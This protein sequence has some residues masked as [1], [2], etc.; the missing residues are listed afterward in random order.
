MI[1]NFLKTAFRCLLKNK[2]FTFINILGLAL[3]LATCLLIVFYVF[4]ELSYDKYNTKCKR[5]YRVNTDLKYNGILTAFGTTSKPVATALVSE[6]PE[7][8]RSARI[9]RALNI[10]FKKGNEIIR[11]DENGTTF[12]CDPGIFEIFT[13]P[14]LYGNPKTALTEPN[15]IVITESI[16]KKYFNR[17][18]VVGQMLFL[19]TDSTTYKIEGVMRDM[20]SQSHFR[21]NFL[22]S[23]SQKPDNN[24]NGIGGFCT[25][26]LLKPGADPKRLE[27]KFIGLMRKHLSTVAGFNY[28]KFEKH[29]NYLRL[30]LTPLK[31]IHLHSNLQWE[32]GA[33]GN[34]QYIYIFSAVALFILLLACI[35]FMNLSTARSANRAREVGVRKVLGSSRKYLIAQFLSESII[36]TL[37]AAIIAVLAAW[38]LLP[39][40]NQ[41]S[42]KHLAITVQIFIW[43]LPSLLSIIIVVGV[44]AGSYPALFLSAF[45]PIDVLKGNLS[46]GFKGGSLRS[47]LIVFQFSISI[48]LVIGTLVVYNQLNYIQN[49]DL[50]FNRDQVLIIKNV[51]AINSP[52]I[53]KREI[54]QLPGVEDAT[55]TSFL[56]TSSSR[57]SNIIDPGTK[58]GPFMQFWSVDEDY[59]NT[60][61]M[62]LK[63]GRN[64]S[65]QFLTD[66]SAM[67]INETAAKMFFNVNEPLNKTLYKYNGPGNEE[68]KYHVIGVVKDFNFSS[69]RDNVTPLVL[70]MAQDGNASLSV[71]VNT[72]NLPFLMKRIESTWKTLAPNLHLEYSFMDDDF[73]AMYSNEQRMVKLFVIFTTL[74]VIIACLGL[75]G[76]AAYAAEQRNREISIRKVLG[77]NVSG[78]VAL[79]S[80]DFIKLV[81]IAIVIATPLAW[82][83]MQKWLQGFAYR[84]HIHWWFFAVTALGAIV[85]A[86]V[87]ISFQSI[88]AAMANPVDSLRSE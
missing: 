2:G 61:G 19:V 63:K 12:Y 70:I 48:F 36:V 77:A 40:F 46:T 41:I 87:T 39:L 80:K 22:M 30:N 33:N 49:K 13:M 58:S 51:N 67:V 82:L 20:P 59:L 37:A 74:A 8:E 11:E 14:M 35:N 28:D 29:G 3:G 24:W 62:K 54:K 25:Y 76:L 10:R 5:I 47:F 66:S 86:F 73:N 85:I 64:F 53:L 60:M 4:D 1:R 84:D 18:N 15:S 79:L 55:L 65:R 7:V 21:A 81:F 69:L 9:T 17:V 38:A 23:L 6:F 31:D 50:G 34:I 42:G 72:G 71:K 26:I 52:E 78:L 43:L 16:A 44:L 68:T 56:P 75:F 88:K 27:T 45:Q 32:L 57:Y 83:V